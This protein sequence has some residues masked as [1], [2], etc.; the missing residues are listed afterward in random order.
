LELHLQKRATESERREGPGHAELKA[1]LLK[2]REREAIASQ[3]EVKPGILRT[4]ARNNILT[5]GWGL[6]MTRKRN[7]R[8]ETER[9][10][11]REQN[12]RLL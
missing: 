8:P 3:V 6:K 10:R 7:S 9:E 5:S 12:E 2:T 1:R 11:D 4:F